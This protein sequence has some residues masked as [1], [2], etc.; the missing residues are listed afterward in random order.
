MPKLPKTR[1]GRSRSDLELFVLGLVG[2]GISTPYTLKSAGLSVG[3]SIP[4]LRRLQA[5]GFLRAGK[6]GPRRR[7]EYAIT[8][9]GRD[10]LDR[11]WPVLWTAAP[12]GDFESILR[13]AALAQL[14]GEP[15]RA[16]ISFVSKASTMR[17][18]HSSQMASAA[19]FGR[20]DPSGYTWMK[21]LSE[22]LRK[23]AEAAALKRV[24]TELRKLK[25]R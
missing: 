25:S 6:E 2:R 12:S 17:H 7:L 10:Y 20:D 4:V 3:G 13:T 15:K 11:E 14:M 8:A 18:S 23:K 1:D 21:E 22:P 19:N 9:K 16:I 24:A 5:Q